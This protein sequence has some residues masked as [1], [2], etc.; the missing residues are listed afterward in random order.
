MKTNDYSIKI[1]TK[2]NEELCH[3]YQQGNEYALNILC[4]QNKGLVKNIALRYLNYYKHN[5]DLDDLMQLGYVGLIQAANNYDINNKE[6]KFSTY[7][8][9]NSIWMIK[10]AISNYGYCHRIPPHILTNIWKVMVLTKKTNLY[11]LSKKETE[12]YIK[13]EINISDK[14]LEYCFDVIENR[15]LNASLQSPIDDEHYLIDFIPDTN[16]VE[17]EVLNTSLQEDIESIISTLKENEQEVIRLR[18]FNDMT[19]EAIGK[20]LKVTKE[21][22]RQIEKRAIEKMKKIAIKKQLHIYLS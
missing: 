8:S 10:R 15:I 21:R 20:I 7:F 18:Y 11:H 14:D 17:N 6:C 22:V 16:T 1:N 3:L 9:Q 12:E 4:E 13:K 19:L 5:I 2:T